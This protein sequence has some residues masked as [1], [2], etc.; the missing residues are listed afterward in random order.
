MTMEATQDRTINY[1]FLLGGLIAA[2][3]GII[4]LI[5]REEAIG[6]LV[7]FLGLWWLIQGAFMIF[8]VF[9]DR[10]DWGWKVL[11]GLLGLVAGVAV[12]ANPIE[13]ASFLGSALAIFLGA[14][15]VVMGVVAIVGSLRGGGFGSLVF[16]IVSALIGLLF[17]FNPIESVSLLVTIFAVLLLVDGV[18]GIYLAMRYR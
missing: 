18:A 11:L 12:M 13:S 7:V 10:A 1:G 14:I 16:G 4:L 17:I 5:R 3:F 15:G 2:L 8:S 6:I 9:I